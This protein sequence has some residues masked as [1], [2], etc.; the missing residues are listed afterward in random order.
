MNK[1]LRKVLEQS[2]ES[3]G[4]QM[5]G[6]E[7]GR[8]SVDEWQVGMAQ[9]LVAYH[10]AAYMTGAG[11]KQADDVSDAAQVAIGEVLKEQVDYLNAFADAI[12]DADVDPEQFAKWRARANLYS[13]ALK[14]SYSMG[15]TRLLD[16]PAHPGQGSECLVNCGCE[17][18]IVEV[19]AENGD[20]DCYWERGKDDSCP[21]CMAREDEWAPFRIREW[22]P[23]D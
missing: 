11:I 9:D 1:Q 4:F 3:I 20:V 2:L 18:R 8:L 17:W 15:A 22:E 23:V 19:D 6:L 16:L 7:S 10:Y 12:D 5:D 13:G 14:T 21:T